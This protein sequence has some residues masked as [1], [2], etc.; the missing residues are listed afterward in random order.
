[1]ISAY[2]DMAT[3][4]ATLHQLP[5]ELLT[6][7]C[8]HLDLTDLVRASATCKRFRHGGLETVELP[9]E[10]PVVT[11][12]SKCAFPRPELIPSMRPAGCSESWVAYFARTVRQRRCLE[13][14]PIA[15]GYQHSL[16]LD[17]SGRLL[18]CGTGAGVGHDDGEVNYFLPTPVAAM[19]GVLI[20]SVAARFGHSLALGWDGRVYSW[21]KNNFGQLGLGDLVTRRS[22]VRVEGLEGVRGIA[23]HA[24][25]SLAVTQSGDVFTWGRALVDTCRGQDAED[26]DEDDMPLRPTMVEGFGHV[27]VRH[28]CAATTTTF[29]IGEAGE[30]F[31][32]GGGCCGLLGHGDKRHKPSPKRIE[33]LHG[34][35]VSDVS[36]GWYHALALAEDELVY[37]WGENESRAL[38]GNPDVEKELSPKPIEALRGVRVRSIAVATNRSYAVSDTGELWAWGASMC[39]RVEVPE[40]W[41]H[42]SGMARRR[43]VLCPSRLRR[44]GAS[45]WMGSPHANLSRV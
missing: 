1:M 27:R 16:F 41:L 39:G 36:A 4:A 43:R 38:L 44:C 37:A 42:R 35:R 14:P 19:A 45:R 17:A 2:E 31:S 9:T 28:V 20:R 29:A 5:L 11:V 33:A 40:I 6:Q 21:G 18:S 23:A 26:M 7:L 12:L 24:D 25:Q 30:I 32:W 34:V 8:Q 3:A 15:D 10:S 22:P 13:A